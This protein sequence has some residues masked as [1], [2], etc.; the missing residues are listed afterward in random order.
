MLQTQRKRRRRRRRQRRRKR[1]TRKKRGGLP[2]PPP[3]LAE[4]INAHELPEIAVVNRLTGAEV[5]FLEPDQWNSTLTIGEL[6]TQVRDAPY[7]TAPGPAGTGPPPGAPGVDQRMTLILD[8]LHPPSATIR[9]LDWCRKYRAH[10][11]APEHKCG[12]DDT[13]T[14]EWLSL[15]PV[16]EAHQL[17]VYRH[18]TAPRGF[19]HAAAVALDQMDY[20]PAN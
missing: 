2:P 7:F 13:I 20:P 14:F 16:T 1:K 9:V 15:G 12:G 18:A 19:R 10:A 8:G 11:A 17:A 3:E 6:R 5:L 4:I